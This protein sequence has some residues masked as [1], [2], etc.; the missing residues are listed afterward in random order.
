[1]DF[2]DAADRFWAKVAKKSNAECWEWTACILGGGYGQFVYR[3]KRYYAHRVSAALAGLAINGALV[4]HT[5]DNRRCVNPRHM[6]VGTH[7]E[8][9]A[10]MTAKRRQRRGREHWNAK[11]SESDAV[12]VRDLVASGVNAREVGRRIGISD[13]HVRDIARGRFWK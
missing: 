1:M 9:M 10:D 3:G 12:M 13:T 5:C 4:M 8:N 2:S 11:L 7:A 6:R